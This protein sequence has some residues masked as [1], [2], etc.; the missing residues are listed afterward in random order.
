MFT[1]QNVTYKD[2][3][4]VDDLVLDDVPV[5]AISYQIAIMLGTVGAIS[6]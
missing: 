6:L 3:V 5:T 1:L 2:I 4:T